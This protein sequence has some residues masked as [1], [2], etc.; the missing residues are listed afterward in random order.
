MTDMGERLRKAREDAGFSSATK[1]ADALGVSASTYRAHENGQNEF[2]LREAQA[3]GKK[4]K[5]DSFW[6][7]SGVNRD[8][9]LIK[10]TEER[11]AAAVEE[12]QERRRRSS[13]ASGVISPGDIAELDIH[14]GMGGG[15]LLHV[16]SDGDGHVAPEF[17]SGHWSFPDHVKSSIRNIKSVYALPVIG[18]SMEP[19]ILGGAIVFVDTKHNTPSPPDIYAVDY[20]DGLMV[21]RIELLPQS[22]LIKVIS[23][24]DRYSNY[25]L[26]RES[27]AVYGRV[28]ASFQ[29]RG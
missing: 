24:N 9:A 27:V 18:D 1:A 28:I 20:G 10:Y 13:I 15:G 11:K 25:D 14:A 29:W 7:L 19:T 4:F 3:Y 16:E 5:V 12:M 2:G 23:D 17:V 8:P 21:K 6:L 22:E 26:S